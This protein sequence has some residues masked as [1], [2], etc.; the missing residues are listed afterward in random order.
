MVQVLPAGGNRTNAD[1]KNTLQNYLP[2]MFDEPVA[3]GAPCLLWAQN[4]EWKKQ[5]DNNSHPSLLH[6]MDDGHN[7]NR[8]TFLSFLFG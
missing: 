6:Q 4:R 7:A 3:A 5:K 8:I 2:Q 1:K